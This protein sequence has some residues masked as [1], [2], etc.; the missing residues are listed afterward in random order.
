MDKSNKFYNISIKSWLQDNGI[1]VYSI[2]NEGKS[3]AAERFE[4]MV[5]NKR[6]SC[7]K[8]VLK[9]HLHLSN[10]GEIRVKFNGTA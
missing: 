7:Q 8:K 2:H 1:E 4:P 5:H 6:K 3:V 10:Y 9:L